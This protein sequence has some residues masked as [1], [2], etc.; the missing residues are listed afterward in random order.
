MAWFE[1]HEQFSN[2]PKIVD[3][4][5][6]LSIPKSQVRGH[7]VSLWCWATSYAQDGDLSKKSNRSIANAADWEGDP[8]AFVT[9]LLQIGWLDEDRR[10]HDWDKMGV[11]LL[12][13]NRERQRKFHEKEKPEPQRYNNV[14]VT[15]GSRSTD[16]TDLTDLTDQK[17]GESPAKTSPPPSVKIPESLDTPD[18][19]DIW[20]KYRRHRI[21]LKPRMTPMAE[22]MALHKLSERDVGTAIAMIRESIT[23][24]WKGIFELKESY[25][26]ANGKHN[27]NGNRER[28]TFTS[29]TVARIIALD[30]P[31]TAG[32]G[33]GKSNNGNHPPGGNGQAALAA[34]ER[35]GTK[36]V[37][38]APG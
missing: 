13:G 4:A 30:P 35:S 19:C 20:E 31:D 16:H 3:M 10:L 24:G 37:D 17:I 12:Y 2:H 9:S 28:E 34:V 11:R 36:R 5:D 8:E 32:S 38:A 33:Q 27:R 26:K 25:E 6:L 14:S 1:L 15:L 23:N 21:D 22:E 18:F 7:I 29:E